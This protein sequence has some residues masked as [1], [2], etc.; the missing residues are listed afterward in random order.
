MRTGRTEVGD[1]S[2]LLVFSKVI[3]KSRYLIIIA[4]LGW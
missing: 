2:S 1:S 4:S 3:H